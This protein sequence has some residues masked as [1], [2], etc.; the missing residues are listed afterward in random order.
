MQQEAAALRELQIGEA[1]AK[2]DATIDS[3]D[4]EAD[5][6]KHP[7]LEAAVTE[8]RAPGSPERLQGLRATCRAPC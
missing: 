6:D 3:L 8:A 7:A 4:N 2:L 5:V 1:E